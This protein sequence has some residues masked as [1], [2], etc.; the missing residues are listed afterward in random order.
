MKKKKPRINS[1]KSTLSEEIEDII[2]DARGNTNPNVHEPNGDANE[3]QLE[4]P[5]EQQE[6]PDQSVR[7]WTRETITWGLPDV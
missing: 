7:R 2:R 4:H 5:V 1:N 3:E 6:A